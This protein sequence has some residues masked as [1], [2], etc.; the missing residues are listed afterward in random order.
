M[1]VKP[2]NEQIVSPVDT[3]ALRA[4]QEPHFKSPSGGVE[5]SQAA[6]NFQENRLGQVLGFR[7]VAENS[8]SDKMNE[9]MVAFENHRERIGIARLHLLDEL[10][11]AQREQ[12]R[13]GNAA[14]IASENAFLDTHGLIRLCN[15]YHGQWK[16]YDGKIIFSEWDKT[17]VWVV[18][19]ETD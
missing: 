3:S 8:Q 11:I 1:A 19:V 5:L 13:I 7:G 2:A 12:F 6:V 15:V 10:L 4:L 17:S 9:A 14:G 18:S 16:K